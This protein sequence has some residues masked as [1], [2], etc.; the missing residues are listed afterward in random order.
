MLSSECFLLLQ[1]LVELSIPG[2]LQ[3]NVDALRVLEVGV[4][5]DYVGVFEMG[6]HLD[7]PLHLLDY[8]RP[9]QISLE[10]NL[11]TTDSS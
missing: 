6:L 4:Q 3:H 11:N 7:F 8:L 10:Q 9:F 5:S 1:V 2:I